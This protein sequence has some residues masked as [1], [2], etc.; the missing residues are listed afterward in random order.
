MVASTSVV[1]GMGTCRVRTSPWA[2]A[3]AFNVRVVVPAPYAASRIKPSTGMA[4][5]DTR[6]AILFL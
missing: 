3:S 4:K 5:S 1:V 6:L 2:A